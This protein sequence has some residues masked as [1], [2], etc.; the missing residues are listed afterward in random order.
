MPTELHGCILYRLIV[1]FHIPVSVALPVLALKLL[2]NA[3]IGNRERVIIVANKADI[4]EFLGRETGAS[5]VHHKT[6]CAEHTL[7][8][9][10]RVI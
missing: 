3:Y 6:C 1:Y 2:F 9:H 8:R 7:N 5:A 10:R 4:V